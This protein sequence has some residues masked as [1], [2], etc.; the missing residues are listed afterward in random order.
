MFPFQ[1]PLIEACPNCK[2]KNDFI[3]KSD[4]IRG[5]ETNCPKCGAKTK[6]VKLSALEKFIHSIKKTPVF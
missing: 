4:C 6:L 2:W 5:L 3:I 1:N